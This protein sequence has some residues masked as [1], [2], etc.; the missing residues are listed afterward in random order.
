LRKV[1][2]DDLPKWGKEGHGNENTI[3]WKDSIGHKIKFIYDNIEGEIKIIDYYK[4]NNKKYFLKVIYNNNI[5]SINIQNIINCYLNE[6]LGFKTKKY[7]Y[8][9]GDIIETK[10]GKIEILEQIRIYNK[11]NKYSN[12][13]YK[14]SCLIDGN[15]DEIKESNLTKGGGCNI[16]G[17]NKVLKYYNDLWTTHPAIAR[18][19]KNTENGY[20]INHGSGKSEIF[21]C[22]DCGYEKS[23][24]L[25]YITKKGFLC[26]RCRDGISY[27]NKFTF[28]L[29]EQLNINF[30]PEFSPDWIG[31]K[32]Y[33]FYFELNDKEYILEMDGGL[34][35]GNIDG[36]Y[37]KTAIETQAIDDYKDM[38]A[39]KHNIEV[40]RIDCLKSE[41]EYIK[42]NILDSKLNDLF[43]LNN[44]DWL[45]CHKFA[46]INLV[47]IA[48]D[49]WNDGIKNTIE[50]SKIIKLNSNTIARYLKNGAELGW[51]DYDPKEEMIINGKING[52]RNGKPIIQLSLIGEYISEF[53][54]ATEVEKKLNISHSL[55]SRCCLRK[56]KTAYGFNWMFKK[57]YELIHKTT[58]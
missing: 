20:V 14:Y 5:I 26:P 56:I 24:I 13:G 3:N 40:I 18:L 2:L 27:P 46:L 25:N 50:I 42:I 52:K 44:I 38:K 21:V 49:L 23:F 16:C 33:D 1:F 51:C 22:P 4:I 6:L 58:I 32:R 31:K 37:G 8:N 28:N 12:K 45:Q 39:K 10:T 34:G 55:I 30:T 7:K 54:S 11:N 36:V 35:H 15:I 43:D 19:L 41:L 48:C 9:I 53:E 57:D 47:K 29:L 17:N